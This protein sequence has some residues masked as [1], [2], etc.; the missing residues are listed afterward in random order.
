MGN[1]AFSMFLFHK[2]NCCSHHKHAT[3]VQTE[4]RMILVTTGWKNCHFL[5]IRKKLKFKVT[6]KLTSPHCC[7]F[8]LFY[9]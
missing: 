4:K 1:I 5:V 2:Y 7:Y 8:L 3:H 6:D 9:A